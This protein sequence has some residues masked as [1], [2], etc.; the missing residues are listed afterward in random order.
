M[1]VALGCGIPVM[2]IGWSHKY[3]EVLQ[4]FNQ[5]DLVID[6]QKGSMSE[7][8]TLLDRLQAT[9]E[10]RRLQILKELSKVRASSREQFDFAES[11]IRGAV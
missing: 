4:E 7:I 5:Q 10:A 11:I 2:V 1:I 3:L 6:Y 9:R 8:L